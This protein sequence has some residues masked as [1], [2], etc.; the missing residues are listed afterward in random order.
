MSF[1]VRVLLG[2]AAGLLLGIGISTTATPWIQRIPDLVEPIGL[3]FVNA[4]R[5]TVIP[6]VVASLIAGVASM[7]NAQAVGRLGGR[8]FAWFLGA[9]AVATLFGAACAYP[10][11]ARLQIDPAVAASLRAT[12]ASAAGR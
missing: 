3:L 1:T 4:I 9:L 7:R 6:L 8:A 5:M 11:L 2:L 12:A 10:L